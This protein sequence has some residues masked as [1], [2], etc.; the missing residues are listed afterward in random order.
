[1]AKHDDEPMGSAGVPDF[2]PTHLFNWNMLDMAIP[3]TPETRDSLLNSEAMEAQKP[4][5]QCLGIVFDVVVVPQ[6][7]KTNIKWPCWPWSTQIKLSSSLSSRK[8]QRVEQL[9][10][11][12]FASKVQ[13]PWA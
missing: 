2:K 10:L 8:L 13:T 6:S 12:E 1:M 4:N 3:S 5:H 11:S 7:K 9:T